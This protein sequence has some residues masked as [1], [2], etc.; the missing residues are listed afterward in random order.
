MVAII[1][2]MSLLISTFDTL[3]KNADASFTL[4]R[5]NQLIYEFDAAG[6][7]LALRNRQNQSLTFSRDG[8]GRVTQVT[9]PVS[10]VFLRY[11]YNAEGLLETVS[12]PLG[13]HLS[14]LSF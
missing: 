8:A 2:R 13:R 1:P 4:T 7:L 3:V 10:G 5:K 12:D 14:G 9:E 6:Q 11:A